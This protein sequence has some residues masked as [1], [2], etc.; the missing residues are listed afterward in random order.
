MC[1][2]KKLIISEHFT[3]LKSLNDKKEKNTNLK[4]SIDHNMINQF[5]KIFNHLW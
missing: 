3:V 5:L 1:R 4:T 2:K